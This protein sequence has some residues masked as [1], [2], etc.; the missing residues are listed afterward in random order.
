MRREEGPENGPQ[1]EAQPATKAGGRV[2]RWLLLAVLIV[3]SLGIGVGI[4]VISPYLGQFVK[5]G[6]AGAFLVTLICSATI[7]FPT[8]G[9]IIVFAMVV[10]P[11]FSW[12]LVALMAGLGGGLGESTAY[13][14]GYGGNVIIAPEQWRRYRRAEEWTRRYGGFAV[15]LFSLAPFLPFDLAGIVAGGMRYPYW[16]FL[17]ATLAGRIIRSFSESYLVYI[18]WRML[19][20]FGHFLSTLDWWGWLL[21][22]GGIVV[23]VVGVVALVLWRRHVG[24]RNAMTDLQGGGKH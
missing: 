14:A 6:Y 4:Y 13:L 1:G 7:F 21:V 15:F 12:P 18:G 9:F 2:R 11:A 22:V 3:V 19:P 10:S 17:S 8:P 24:A 20:G 5:Y 16:R 23:I